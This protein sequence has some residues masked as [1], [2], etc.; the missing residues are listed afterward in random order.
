[1]RYDKDNIY[2]VFQV[3]D[4]YVKAANFYKCADQTSHPHWLTWASVDYPQPKF[5]LPEFF[6]RL[7]FE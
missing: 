1:M 2:V 4:K 6:G 7:V 3:M 5:H